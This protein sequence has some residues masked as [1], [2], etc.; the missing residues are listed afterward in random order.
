ME[1][2]FHESSGSS[3]PAWPRKSSGPEGQS[4][5]PVKKLASLCLRPCLQAEKPGL[6]RH[7]F[8][9]GD[10]AGSTSLWSWKLCLLRPDQL[11]N[12]A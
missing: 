10:E 5:Y 4:C 2:E 11:Y 1:R 9:Y 8:P 7:S 12:R 3:I 6:P